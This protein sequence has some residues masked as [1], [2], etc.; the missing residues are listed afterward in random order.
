MV[1]AGPQDSLIE[2]NDLNTYHIDLPKSPQYFRH[3]SVGNETIR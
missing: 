3:K 1:A 2:M